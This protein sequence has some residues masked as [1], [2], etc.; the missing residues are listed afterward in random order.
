MAVQTEGAHTGEFILSESEGTR[1]REVITLISGQNL[2]SGTVLG[3][4]TAS[5]KYTKYD[6]ASALGQ[7]VAAGIL[8]ANVD[9][10]A[11]DTKAV[12]I[13]RDAEVKA[14]ALIWPVTADATEKAAAKVAF[15]ANGIIIRA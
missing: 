2:A 13:V 14:G 4:I 1:S 5:G 6:D 9:A 15:A 12:V 11:G 7:Q 10:S 3:I 8:Y